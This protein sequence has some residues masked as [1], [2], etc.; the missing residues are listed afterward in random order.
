MCQGDGGFGPLLRDTCPPVGHGDG[1]FGPRAKRAVNIVAIAAAV[2]AVLFF[3]ACWWLAGFV[4]TGTRQALD[5]AFAWQSEHYDTSF[6]E[7]LVK[8]DFTVEGSGGYILHAQELANPSPTDRYVII[9]HGYTDNRMG[10]LKYVPLYL[11]LGYNCIVY[12]LRGH[13]LNEAT[14]TTYGLLEGQ[15]L[16]R[17]VEDTRARHPEL[18]QLGLHGESLGAASTI[19][20]LQ[21]GPAVDFVVSDCA[22]EDIMGVLREGYKNAGAPVFLVDWANL[23]AQMRYHYALTDMRPIDALANNQIPILYLH[24]AEDAFIVPQ[25]AQDLYDATT[26]PRDLH[27]IEQ[28]AHAESVLV[29]PV[30]YKTYVQ[31]FLQ[32]LARA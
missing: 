15:D 22:F 19:S 25:N 10:A 20:C 5:E 1:G 14:F 26:S 12:D 8:T 31:D 28:A 11:D 18:S 21:Y 27:F 4:M 9:S 3:A 29:D 13:G 23:G 6:Y 7:G 32:E 16:A 17:L 24:G 2:A 30:A